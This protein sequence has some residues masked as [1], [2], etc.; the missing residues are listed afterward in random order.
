[1]PPPD[2]IRVGSAVTM[3]GV[4]LEDGSL[5]VLTAT[6]GPAGAGNPP[7]YPSVAPQVGEG[8]ENQPKENPALT[9]HIVFQ[10]TRVTPS[11]FGFDFRHGGI[12][13]LHGP[14]AARFA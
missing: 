4:K 12:H 1:M 14:V 9:P 13:Q 10:V 3:T 5:Q 6:I 2:D 7:L 8:L 11:V